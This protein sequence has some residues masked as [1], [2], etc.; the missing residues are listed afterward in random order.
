MILV[1]HEPAAVRAIAHRAI[2]LDHGRIVRE[3]TP[4]AVL[5]PVDDPHPG[6]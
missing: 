4:A 1:S 5:A 3:G 6:S 2:V